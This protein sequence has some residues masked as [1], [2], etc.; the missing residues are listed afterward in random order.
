V[1]PGPFWYSGMATGMLS[2]RY[3]PEAD[4][5]D[6]QQLVCRGGG[7]FIRDKAVSLDTATRR[8]FLET[9]SSLSYDVLSFNLG[10]EVPTWTIPGLE[11]RA[12]AVKPIVNLARLRNEVAARSKQASESGPLRIVLIG[13]GATACEIAGNLCGLV[14]REEGVASITILARGAELMSTWPVRS[15]LIAMESLRSR[16]V[17]ICLN[18]PALRV[19]DREVITVDGRSVPF[20]LLI[21]AHG[22]VPARMIRGTGLP[23]DEHGALVVDDQLRSIADPAIFGGGDCIALKGLELARVGV[24]GVRQAPILRHN[25]LAAL[26]KRPEWAFRSFQPQTNSLLIMNMGDGTGL[27]GRGGWTW[28]GS[29]A[30]QLKD[31]IDRRFLGQYQ[32]D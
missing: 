14:E 31:W 3:P 24:H 17:N 16:A 32:L 23:T 25:L 4:T 8:V 13:G 5:I 21:A 29:L 7:R 11:D 22:L 2:G 6:V 30:L 19:E 20:D 27:A 1:A 18:S 15:Q 26:E 10:S 28:H 12:F 9:G